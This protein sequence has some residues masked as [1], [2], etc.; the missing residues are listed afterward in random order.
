MSELREK[1]IKKVGDRL[2]IRIINEL[3]EKLRNRKITEEELDKILELTLQTYTNSL[4][5]PGEPIGTV[6]AQSIGEPGTQMT[7]RTFHYAGVRELNVTLGLPRLIEIVDARKTP[8]TPIMEIYLDEEHRHDREKA[9]EVAQRIE[10]TKV[11][12]VASVIEADLYTNSIRIVLDPEMLEDKGLTPEQV[13]NT[14]RKLNI[15][16]TEME[17]EYTIVVTLKETADLNYIARKKDRITNTKL[18]G[19]SGIKR[20]IIQSRKTEDGKEEYVIV[21]DG[22]NLAQVLKIKGVDPT[23]TRTNNI[24]EIEQILGIEAARRAIIDEIMNVLKEQGLD[25]DVRHVYLV[26]DI[27]TQTGRVRQI[28][29]HGV[30]GEKES[31][32][33][34]AAFEMTTKHL[35][36]AA[37]QGKTDPLKGVTENVIVGQ[38]VPVGT[39]MVDLYM[40]PPSLLEESHKKKSG[41]KKEEKGE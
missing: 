28:G 41:K 1:I 26:A 8:S 11:E 17:N 6:T 31:F 33:A 34:R 35:F 25:V 5:D 23:R 38:I 18:K 14:I 37:I 9:K 16:K 22:S 19:V 40:I 24:T 21:T 3:T 13:Y 15:G 12:N 4:V 36:E 39:G 27:M 32:L 29:R 10:Y 2:P 7:L 20:A 30:S